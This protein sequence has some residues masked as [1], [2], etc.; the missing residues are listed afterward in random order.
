MPEC[1]VDAAPQRL[2]A[3]GRVVTFLVPAGYVHSTPHGS[4]INRGMA[5][6]A[7]SSAI[8]VRARRG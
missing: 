3:R 8:I 1:M 4:V 5:L 6:A 2:S 7:L